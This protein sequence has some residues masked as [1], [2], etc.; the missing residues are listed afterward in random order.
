MVNRYAEVENGNQF[1]PKNTSHGGSLLTPCRRVLCVR[2]FRGILLM[3]IFCRKSIIMA[4]QKNNKRTTQKKN[5]KAKA[6]VVFWLI[7]V[8]VI[9]CVSL[10]NADTISKNFNLFRTRL[11]NPS[12]AFED[13][14]TVDVSTNGIDTNASSDALTNG[15]PFNQTISPPEVVVVLDPDP[16]PNSAPQAASQQATGQTATGQ[17]APGQASPQTAGQ[18]QPQA[19]PQITGQTQTTT[20]SPPPVQTR[21]RD[22]YFAQINSD[23]QILQSKASRRLPITETPMQDVLGAMLSGPNV[24]ELNRNVINFV[25]RNTRLLSATVRG[26]TAYLNFSEDFM[27]NTFGVEGYV[28]QLRQIVWTVTE[29][30]NVRDVQILIEG[31]RLDYLGDGIWIG[32][33]I[34]RGSF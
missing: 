7:F 6:V 4:V 16:I 18:T 24:D 13:S 28:A 14:S 22:I 5:T 10:F 29:F 23:G 3:A 12:G 8:L 34:G 27:F 15:Q 32:S 2:K 26:S 30:P 19:S 21:E 9:I 31:Q 20:P 17:T 11:A 25:P 33:P 1:S